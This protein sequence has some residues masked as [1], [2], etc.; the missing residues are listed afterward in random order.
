[1]SGGAS[2]VSTGASESD[3]SAAAKRDPSV[4]EDLPV[5][6][7]RQVVKLALIDKCKKTPRGRKA[8]AA[9]PTSSA[10]DVDE[11]EEED[12]DERQDE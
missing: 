4:L 3:I 6:T 9:G 12:N 11:E 5:E 7:L 2:F 10:M 8:A 1:M